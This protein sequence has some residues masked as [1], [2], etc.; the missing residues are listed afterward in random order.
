M[1]DSVEVKSRLHIPGSPAQAGRN[2]DA[3]AP[4]S[5][6]LITLSSVALANQNLPRIASAKEEGWTGQRRV[7][8]TRPG[9][10][11]D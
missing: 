1:D 6:L 10:H 5:D 3:P 9:C 7:I 11:R 4:R 2:K 8:R